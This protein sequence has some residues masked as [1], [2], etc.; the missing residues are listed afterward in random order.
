[1]REIENE[2]LRRNFVE[3]FP[4]PAAIAYFLQMGSYDINQNPTD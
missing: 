1:L 3:Y 2:R 4:L